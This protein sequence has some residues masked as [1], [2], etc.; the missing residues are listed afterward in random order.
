MTSGVSAQNVE[1]VHSSEREEGYVL[2]AWNA[3]T[4]GMA[5]GLGS[6]A[7]TQGEHRARRQSHESWTSPPLQVAW[8]RNWCDRS[9]GRS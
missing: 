7:A 5:A 9:E 2:S 8:S 4:E 6:I 3:S 1:R